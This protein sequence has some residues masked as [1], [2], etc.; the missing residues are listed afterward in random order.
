MNVFDCIFNRRG[1]RSFKREPVD[2]KLI[3]V[4]LYSATQAPSAGNTQEWQFV[5]VKDAEMRKKLADAA[6]RQGF[7]AEAPVVIVVCADLEKI[8][9]RFGKR[10]E[11]LYGVQDTANATM[12]MMLAAHALGLSTCW[13]GAFDEDAVSHVVELPEKFKPVAIVPVGYAL[14]SPEKPERI[15]FETLASVNAFGKKYDISYAAGPDQGKEIRFTPIGDYIEGAFK[16]A[17]KSVKMSVGKKI[18]GEEGKEGG[19]KKLTFSEFLRRLA[20]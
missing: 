5:V 12:L 4:M 3:G 11:A 9:M 18:A 1:V 8:S 17:E 15:P 7:I 10:G 14:E 20:K 2:D 6:L 13:V 19:K 16:K